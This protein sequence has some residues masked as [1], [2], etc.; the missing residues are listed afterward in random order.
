[1]PP[2]RNSSSIILNQSIPAKPDTRRQ[3]F[4][5]RCKLVRPFIR[6]HASTDTKRLWNEEH[7]RGLAVSLLSIALHAGDSAKATD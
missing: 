2:G 6:S 5:E 7:W 3:L 4:E 1:M